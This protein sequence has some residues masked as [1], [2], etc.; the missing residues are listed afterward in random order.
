M[1]GLHLLIFGTVQGVYYRKSTQQ[2]ASTLR[3]KGWV[4]NR[5]EGQVELYAEGTET[6]LIQLLQWCG[7]GPKMAKVVQVDTEWTE[8][9]G[10]YSSFSIRATE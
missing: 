10:K 6:D 7:K 2:I 8:A 9:K 3:L 5:K 1:K 4:R